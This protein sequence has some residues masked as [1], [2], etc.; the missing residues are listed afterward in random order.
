MKK[1]ISLL[2]TL[3][4]IITL[5]G[6]NSNENTKPIIQEE[7]VEENIEEEPI[8]GGWKDAE[9]GTIT[10]ELND[11]FNDAIKELLGAEYEPIELVATQIVAGTNYKFLAKGTKTTNP[12]IEG[13]YYITVYKDINGNVELKDIETIEEKEIKKE[14]DPTEYD[15]WVVFYNPDGNELQRTIEKFGTTP[16]YVGD[17]PHYWDTDY[18]YKFVSWTDKHGNEIK[19]FKPIVGNTYI[20]A[21][22]EIG[23][24]LEKKD[25]STPNNPDHTQVECLTSSGGANG[26]YIDTKVAGS[27]DIQFIFDIKM[28]KVVT[29]RPVGCI[30]D[31]GY[32]T[33]GYIGF[34]SYNN[35]LN[36][37]GGTSFGQYENDAPF[38]S[39]VTMD[40][41]INTTYALLK[42][43]G[44][45]VKQQNM[46]PFAQ[47]HIPNSNIYIFTFN[48]QQ[49]LTDNQPMSI[50]NMKIYKSGT[51]VRDYIPVR[52]IKE[53]DMSKNATNSTENIPID[54][55]CF[56]DQLNG[57]Y[58]LNLGTVD[59][60]DIPIS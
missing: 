47:S 51:L 58:Y 20:Y 54:T 13:T 15:Y 9:D 41:S 25:S 12:K 37:Y 6:C 27:G 56:Y 3:L 18:W 53:I 55:L 57:L 49:G 7:I 21:K 10:D 45:T 5:V 48:G 60:T 44:T 28:K 22:Y 30:A 36:V 17:E 39:K 52:T 32:G 24:D 1:L 31:Y 14:I 33:V 29:N 4:V 38:G 59:F 50:Y 19:Q 43:N 23:G 42:L 40:Y 34:F 26:S 16:K 11:I 46:V 35:G 8:L 2:F